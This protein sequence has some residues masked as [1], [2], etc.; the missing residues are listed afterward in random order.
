MVKLH[1]GSP[2][3]VA[4]KNDSWRALPLPFKPRERLSTL[5]TVLHR[6]EMIDALPEAAMAGLPVNN[7]NGG[8]SL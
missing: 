2:C 6:L 7:D 1:R 8:V 5:W 4:A 3:I